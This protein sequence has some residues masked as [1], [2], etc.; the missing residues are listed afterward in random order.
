VSDET[1]MKTK[2]WWWLHLVVLAA[3]PAVGDDL[4]ARSP[5]SG[6]AVADWPAAKVAKEA[7]HN[8]MNMCVVRYDGHME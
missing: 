1:A 8:N 7:I 2:A 6:K 5:S 4:P 3:G